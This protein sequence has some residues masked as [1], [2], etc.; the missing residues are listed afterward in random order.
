M[1]IQVKYE[2]L[3]ILL[4]IGITTFTIMDRFMKNYWSMGIDNE[5]FEGPASVKFFDICARVSGR[6]VLVTTNVLFFTQCKV[7]ANAIMDYKPKWLVIDDINEIHNKIHIFVGKWLM[8]LPILIHVW[9]ILFPWLFGINLTIMESRPKGLPF[10][11]DGTVNL[12]YND[13][14][15]LILMTILF[16]ILF[17]YSV[18]KFGRIRSYT[19]TTF[20]HIF[21]ALMY[22]IDL[23]R[24][25]SHPHAHVF[26]TPFVFMWMIDRLLGA[27]YYRTGDGIIKKKIKIDDEYMILFL[28]IPNYNRKIGDC[29]WLNI[30]NIGI[31]LSHP[32][33]TFHNYGKNEIP[34]IYEES[35]IKHKFYL[36]RHENSRDE[37][38]RNKTLSPSNKEKE[39]N[40]W[41]I[42]ILMKIHQKKK[43]NCM[44]SLGWTKYISTDKVDDGMDLNYYGPYRT[45]YS[46][47]ICD[48]LPP[49]ILIGSG[50][51]GAYIIDFYNYI[52]SN[53]I[54]L[55]NKVEIYYTSS[56]IALFQLITDI[57][58]KNPI[59]NFIV[60][61]HITSHDEEVKYNDIESH[62][63]DMSIG[64]ASFEEIL[65]EA[66]KN[67]EVYFCGS[68]FLQNK[69]HKICNKYKIE[70]KK[71]HSFG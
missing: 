8:G 12:A 63:V 59:E 62:N 47:L 57:I 22:T 38:H 2:H 42:G 32:F 3:F 70:L 30:K 10:F 44:F 1:G 23:L 20:I 55:K 39:N 37:F 65:K 66:S 49:L 18:S 29:Y 27:Y 13:V 16:L 11:N 35:C 36:E 61:A 52:V 51:G 50:A 5:P 21:A 4:F 56:S 54:Q 68:P 26:N 71:G 9:S 31:E 48:N 6:L 17:P 15:R 60:N 7:C 24:M 34:L 67:T 28:K 43:S 33:T 58:C 14:Y 53:N 45:S 40:E 25:P 41:N 19:I 64:R 69:I 46:N